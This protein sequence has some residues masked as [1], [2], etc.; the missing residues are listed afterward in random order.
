[1]LVKNN[2]GKFM[3]YTLVQKLAIPLTY[4]CEKL[5][6]KSSVIHRKRVGSR[7]LFTNVFMLA[8]RYAKTTA[9]FADM[10]E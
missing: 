6:N 4:G 5:P 10:L 2:T 1:M 7:V 9:L 3:L 8:C